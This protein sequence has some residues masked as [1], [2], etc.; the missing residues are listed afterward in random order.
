MLYGR[1]NDVL[2]KLPATGIQEYVRLI[3]SI[4]SE[5][6]TDYEMRI[7][8]P[9]SGLEYQMLWLAESPPEVEKTKRADVC[10]AI[11]ACRDNDVHIN[12]LK[13]KYCFFRELQYGVASG[14]R[15]PAT[16]YTIMRAIACAWRADTQDIESI[17]SLIKDPERGW[18]RTR[19]QASRQ[20]RH[21]RDG[22]FQCSVSVKFA[23]ASPR[24]LAKC[25]CFAVGALTIP[26]RGLC[27]N[28]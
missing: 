19:S 13:L 1:W 27:E 24:C 5:H 22:S 6:L 14:G 9:L 4:T 10:R 3:A 2:D 26:S 16:L 12:V 15:I 28:P 25:F 17:N 11:L 18:G 21:S 8:R 20:T 23:D 7:L